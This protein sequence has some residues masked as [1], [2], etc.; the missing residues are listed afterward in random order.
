MIEERQILNFW[1]PKLDGDAI[2]DKRRYM[3]ITKDNEKI[4][5]INISKMDG[6]NIKQLLKDYNIEL[7]DYY[8]FKLPS[9]AKTNTL[10]TIEY[11][12]ELENFISFGGKKLNEEDFNNI[13]L[14]REEYV[15]K[16]GNNKIINF[17]KEE[18]LNENLITLS[19]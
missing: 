15:N 17:T 7:K 10:Y 3:I 2:S 4:E 9:F 8:P 16:T 1:P 14:A 12:P 13:I 5:M 19:S 6:K 18:F 11:F